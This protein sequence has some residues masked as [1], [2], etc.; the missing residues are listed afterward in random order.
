MYFFLIFTFVNVYIVDQ[1]GNIEGQGKVGVIFISKLLFPFPVSRGRE[2]I[3]EE[4]I[5][6]LPTIPVTG[7]GEWLLDT[8]PGS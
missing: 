7:D 3:R 5:L 1:S 6:G 4:A 2:E 8:D